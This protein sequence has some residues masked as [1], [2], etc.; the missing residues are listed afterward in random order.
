MACVSEKSKPGHVFSKPLTSEEIIT[1]P[2]TKKQ[3]VKGKFLGKV[4]FFDVKDSLC[5]FLR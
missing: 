2:D 5:R 3:Y 1:N 4:S